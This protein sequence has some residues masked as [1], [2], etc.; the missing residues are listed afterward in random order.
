MLEL[1]KADLKANIIAIPEYRDD[2]FLIDNL[3]NSI[4]EQNKEYSNNFTMNS[5]EIQKSVVNFLDNY[6]DLDKDPI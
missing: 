2:G 1:I 4:L 3:G 5:V 6:F